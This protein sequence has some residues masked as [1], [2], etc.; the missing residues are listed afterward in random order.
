MASFVGEVRGVQSEEMGCITCGRRVLYWAVLKYHMAVQKYSW[1]NTNI[2]P[3]MDE[4]NKRVKT[5]YSWINHHHHPK[6][7]RVF[8]HPKL[9]SKLGF[10]VFGR[11]LCPSSPAE[12]PVAAT[13]AACNSC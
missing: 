8:K 6:E 7:P 13:K 9:H 3:N 12:S 5:H 2:I 10:W 4:I 1:N 11:E